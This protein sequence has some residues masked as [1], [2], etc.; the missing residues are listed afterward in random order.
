MKVTFHHG[1]LCTFWWCLVEVIQESDKIKKHNTKAGTHPAELMMPD[2][3]A[4]C[5]PLSNSLYVNIG[6]VRP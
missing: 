2:K 1:V 5:A 4:V 6:E 3:H